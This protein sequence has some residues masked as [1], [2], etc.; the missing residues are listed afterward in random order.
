MRLPGA[1]ALL[2]FAACTTQQLVYEQIPDA[3]SLA[4]VVI[5]SPSGE[6]VVCLPNRDCLVEDA[7]ACHAGFPACQAD[8][9]LGPCQPYGGVCTSGPGPCGAVD[10]FFVLDDGADMD[11]GSFIEA[12]Q[13]IVLTAWENQ[14][15]GFR[16]GMAVT[17]GC[18]ADW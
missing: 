1:C 14:P 11:V 2:F 18:G 10:V 4:P 8:G 15:P 6:T 13:G 5:L 7:G 16:F 9:T 12:Q 3:G 17:P